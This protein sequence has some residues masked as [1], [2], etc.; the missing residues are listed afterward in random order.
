M[1]VNDNLI[2]KFRDT[3]NS[4]SDFV[5]H[6]YQS[7]DGK[8]HWNII[9]SCMDWI[10]VSIR[11]LS[12]NISLD[13]DIDVRVMQFF[14]IISAVDIVYEAINQL[15]RVIFINN[16]IPYHQ[17]IEIFQNNKLGLDDNSYFKELRA[18][19]GAHPVNLKHRNN[20]KWYASWPYDH[21]KS[22][23][24]T[25]ELRLYSNKVGVDDITFGVNINDIEK[26]LKQ[27]YEYLGLPEE[28]LR[29]Y[30]AIS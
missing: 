20:E 25:F 16:T 29:I 7:R 1:N 9:C 26:F 5:L 22:E 17:N 19:F 27:R 23:D 24:S 3:V 30:S 6:S 2:V 13:E 28:Q 11:F 18:M 14:S 10:S 4:N 8:N 15:H 12:K 21:Y